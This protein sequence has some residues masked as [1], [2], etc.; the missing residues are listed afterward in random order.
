MTDVNEI[1]KKLINLLDQNQVD[2]KLFEH[3]EALTYQD[4]ALVQKEVGF[5]GTE[6]K[7]MVLKADDKVTSRKILRR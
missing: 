1:Y 3:R 2:Y 5:F 7:C 4:L 6:M